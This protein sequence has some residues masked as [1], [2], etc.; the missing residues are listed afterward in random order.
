VAQNVIT[1]KVPLLGSLVKSQHCDQGHLSMRNSPVFASLLLLSTGCHRSVSAYSGDARLRAERSYTDALVA[2]VA[3]HALD[4]SDLVAIH[5]QKG[6]GVGLQ[7]TGRQFR[8]GQNISLLLVSGHRRIRSR[9]QHRLQRLFYRDRRCGRRDRSAGA[10][11]PPANLL[12]NS[13]TAMCLW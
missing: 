12:Q 3:Q 6:V 2:D 9:F 1:I 4:P 13:S 7:F 5:Q 10:S 11:P 8:V